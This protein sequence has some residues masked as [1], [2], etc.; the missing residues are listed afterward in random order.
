MRSLITSSSPSLPTLT[1]PLP[2]HPSLTSL[3]LTSPL[4]LPTPPLVILIN[5]RRLV[6]GHT[7]SAPLATTTVPGSGSIHLGRERRGDV[8]VSMDGA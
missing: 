3:P 8:T 2:P 6:I 7:Q 4:L 1:S 5:P